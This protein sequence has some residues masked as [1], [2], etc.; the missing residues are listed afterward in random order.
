MNSTSRYFTPEEAT[1][2]LP[3][4]RHIVSD[5]VSKG[6]E[7]RDLAAEGRGVSST[8]RKAYAEIQHCITELEQFGCLYTDASY[9]ES[10][11]NFPAIIDDERVYLSWHSGEEEVTHY[12]ACD[13]GF[14]SRRP[15]P[16]QYLA[17]PCLQA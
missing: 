16:F 1:R 9:K 17:S 11:V 6:Q 12:H 3:L 8:Y 5:I 15:I 10:L 4:V 2:T 7:L 14:E 13:G